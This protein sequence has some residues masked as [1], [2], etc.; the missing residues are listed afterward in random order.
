[1]FVFFLSSRV[2]L[3]LT[4]DTPDHLLLYTFKNLPWEFCA[5]I[6]RG[7]FI[8]KCE[9]LPHRGYFRPSS[10]FHIWE[11]AVG[12]WCDNFPWLF[13]A[14]ICHGNLPWL[15]ANRI[16][17]RNLLWKFA[18]AICRENL[19]QDFTV[20]ICCGYLLFAFISKS[21]FVYVILFIW[22]QTF[23]YISKTF[24]FVIFSLLTVFHFVI[25]VTVMGH[26]SSQKETN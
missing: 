7:C 23:W 2:K 18:V 26:H 5:T 20:V 17:R 16:F 10:A 8:F 25:A 14:G 24:L 12:I 19:P 6:R 9:A 13:A 4:E 22:K 1:M 11:I 3:S 21:F 15:I